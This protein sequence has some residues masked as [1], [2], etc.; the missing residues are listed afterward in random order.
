MKNTEEKDRSKMA[1]N[2][3]MSDLLLWAIFANRPE[4]TGIL[5]RRG[6]SHLRKTNNDFVN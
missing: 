1:E 4:L 5:W 3:D 6:K 2:A